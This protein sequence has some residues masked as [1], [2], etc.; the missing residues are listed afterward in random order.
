MYWLTFQGDRRS[1][2]K[3]HEAPWQMTV[4]LI[5]L[6]AGTA[7]FWLYIS[8]YTA[9]MAL[10]L[11]QYPVT[12]IPLGEFIHHAFTG[13]IVWVTVAVAIILAILTIK[14][15]GS[16]INAFQRPSVITLPLMKAYWFD[17]FYN[18]CVKGLFSFWHWFSKLQTGY[19]NYNNLG[20]VVGFIVFLVLLFV[21]GT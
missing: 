7:L 17:A 13:P 5:V 2:V 11:P 12:H 9:G 20:I 15:R 10:S 4:P 1:K 19:L 8:P 16:V 21:L 3:V 14:W 18:K 6:A